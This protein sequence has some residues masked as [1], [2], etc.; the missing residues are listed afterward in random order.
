MIRI[1][2][3]SDGTERE[4]ALKKRLASDFEIGCLRLE[5]IS[6]AAHTPHM[7]VDI[8]LK[9]AGQVAA[10][11]NWLQNRPRK[12]RA[13][14][15]V[16][17]GSHLDS[18]RASAAGATSLLARPVEAAMLAWALLG[19]GKPSRNFLEY[20]DESE[21]SV[22]PGTE[23]LRNIF[24]AAI[25]GTMPDLGLIH[26][27][28]GEIAQ[29]I[30]EEG[31]V[32]CLDE[33]RKHHSQTYQ[34][35]LIVTTLAVS[36]GQYLGFRKTDVHRLASAGLLHDIGK[37]RIPLEI[38]EKPGPLD[39]LEMTVMRTH[40]ELGL[41]ALQDA[42]GLQPEML[43]MVVHHHEYLDGSGYPHHL[44]AHE[45]SDLVRTITI[46]DIFGALVERRSY[47]PPMSGADAYQILQDMGPKLD[48]AM[49]R[50]FR[51]LAQT[52]S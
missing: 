7:L 40:P 26:A 16:N 39:E 28:S 48:T 30:E 17:R 14:F 29:K 35:C 12:S 41:E 23:A 38:L 22:A 11:R 43:D 9:N 36:F 32:H 46:A 31:L 42:P 4:Q 20:F 27:A 8:D 34:H 19:E 21:P 52:I 18:L 25:S 44:Q 1:T 37:A 5:D 6:S 10:I 47:R 49:V 3:I 15:V 51:P 13:I 45:I 50:E 24:E 2:L 33:V